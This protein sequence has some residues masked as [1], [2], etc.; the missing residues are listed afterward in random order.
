M[1]TLDK[2]ITQ[3]DCKYGAPLGRD[4]IDN[5]PVSVYNGEWFVYTGKLFDCKVPL[6]SGG[7]DSGGVYWGLGSELRVTY[8]KQLTYIQFYRK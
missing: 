3:V 7:Y 8:N 2:I 5:C 4:N 6:D 1:R